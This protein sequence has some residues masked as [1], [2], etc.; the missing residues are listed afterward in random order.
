MIETTSQKIS[1]VMS[2]YNRKAQTLKTLEG[3][4]NQYAGKYNFEVVIVDDNSNDENSLIQDIKKYS[5]PINLIVI[6][7][8][9]NATTVLKNWIT[10]KTK[11]YVQNVIQRCSK[12]FKS[13][14]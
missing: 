12:N 7:K 4:E 1:I 3:F 9:E 14:R 10:Y 13:A 5:F 6:S 8:E 2:Y 11:K